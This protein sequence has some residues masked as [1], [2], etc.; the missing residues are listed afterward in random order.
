MPIKRCQEN[1]KPGYKCGDG[2]KCYTYTPQ[3]EAERKQALADA[4]AQCLAINE[5]LKE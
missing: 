2:G 3:N 1:N 4:I 5:P